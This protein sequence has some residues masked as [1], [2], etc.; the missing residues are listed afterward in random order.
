MDESRAEHADD[1]RNHERVP[2]PSLVRRELDVVQ[3]RGRIAIG[4]AYHLHQQHT[5]EH[6]VGLRHTHTCAD[7]PVERLDLGVLPLRFLHAATVPTALTHGAGIAAAAHL[8]AFLVVRKLVEA[9]LLH[10]SL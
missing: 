7:E 5:V 2:L 8:A 3:A 6:T 1:L 4:I 10:A 9:A